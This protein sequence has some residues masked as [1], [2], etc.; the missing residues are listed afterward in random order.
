MRARGQVEAPREARDA[1]TSGL[2][3]ATKLPLMPF[4]RCEPTAHQYA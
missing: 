1:S 3:R 2:Q 4:E